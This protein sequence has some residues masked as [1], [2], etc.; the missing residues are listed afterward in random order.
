MKHTKCS[1]LQNSNTNVDS[2]STC[3]FICP[4]G[5]GCGGG[6]TN[7]GLTVQ[8]QGERKK[9]DE[10]GGEKQLKKQGSSV[11]ALG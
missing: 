6:I 3:V 9:G 8:G 11:H 1:Q 5:N 4:L 10:G 7:Y 2:P